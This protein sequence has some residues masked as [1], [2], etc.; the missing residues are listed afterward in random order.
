[1]EKFGPNSLSKIQYPFISVIIK[2]NSSFSTRTAQPSSSA[3]VRTLGFRKRLLEKQRALCGSAEILGKKKVLHL[4]Q[5]L[6]TTTT[7]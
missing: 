7:P 4:Q 6:Y 3:G 2:S 1:M 5:I